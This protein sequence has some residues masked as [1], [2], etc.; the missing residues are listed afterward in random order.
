MKNLSYCSPNKKIQG[1]WFVP[2]FVSTHNKNI[3]NNSSD[4]NRATVLPWVMS[5]L[6]F[7]FLKVR[8]V[9]LLIVPGS[10]RCLMIFCLTYQLEKHHL[11]LWI[12]ISFITFGFLCFRLC[13]KKH[14]HLE[15]LGLS[16]KLTSLLG[17]IS[18]SHNVLVLKSILSENNN[19][20]VPAFV[21]LLF[22]FSNRYSRQLAG[23]ELDRDRGW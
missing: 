20:V 7:L 18:V 22:A 12:F 14:T 5:F 15:M 4:E 11:K 23:Y 2:W 13:Y 19:V 10:S 9:S 21:G 16:S 6:W 8:W 3:N 17:N 1:L